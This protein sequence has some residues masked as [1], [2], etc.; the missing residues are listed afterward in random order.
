MSNEIITPKLSKYFKVAFKRGF[1][2]QIFKTAKIVPI[3]KSGDKN[4]IKNYRPISFLLSLSKVLEKLIKTRLISFFDK[5]N[6]IYDYQYGFREKHSVVHALI[7]VVSRGF[8]TLQ[9]TSYKST[10]YGSPKRF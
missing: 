5:H 3:F 6:V 8:D 1:F 7:D 2:P 4:L 9:K 10:I